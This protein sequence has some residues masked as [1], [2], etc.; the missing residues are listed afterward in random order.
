MGVSTVAREKSGKHM[1]L[2]LY[3]IVCQQL[4][5]VHV[6]LDCIVICVQLAQIHGCWT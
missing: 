3:V 2:V 4:T 1:I 6:G 5:L